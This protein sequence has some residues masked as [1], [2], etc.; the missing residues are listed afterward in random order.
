M[1]QPRVLLAD[2]HEPM[3]QLLAR[4]LADEYKVV[5]AV[6]NGQALLA[7]VP[8]LNPDVVILDIS[9][10]VLGGIET[11]RKIKESDSSAKIVFLTV[12]EDVEYARTCR[13]AGGLGYVVKSRLASDLFVAIKQ[14]L[15]GRL[16]T[17]PIAS[18]ENNL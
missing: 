15:A 10:P 13:A 12:H 9:M 8:E 2:D 16:F 4:L 6:A 14:A 1:D 18:L 3:R 17:S 11:A 7:L 5:G